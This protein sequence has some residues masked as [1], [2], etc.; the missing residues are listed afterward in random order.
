MIPLKDD[1]P[2]GRFPI[3]TWILIVANIG[4]FI[5]EKLV[6]LPY[7]VQKYGCIPF[8]I[9]HGVDLPPYVD[10]PIYVNI[11]TSMF[12]H[13]SWLHLIFNMLFLFVFGDNV[14]D[15][16]GHFKFL[17]LYIIC[18]LAGALS[19]IIA[20][21]NSRIP[22]V[23]ASGAIAGVMGSYL[24]LYP[25][26]KIL[27]IF[28]FFIFIRIIL[29]PAWFYLGYWI[30]LQVLGSMFTPAYTAGVAFL[31]HLGGFFAGMFITL[32]A[33][34]HRSLKSKK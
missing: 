26:A 24:V 1:I 10:T 2:S 18:G 14:E 33:K 28:P 15:W 13:G 29:L 16:F 11:I 23:G 6:G 20:S 7:I 3:I 8:E 12:L 9:I 31:A 32:Y 21:I 5:Y 17:F 27:T 34:I 19:Q 22:M 30:A 4:I 25:R